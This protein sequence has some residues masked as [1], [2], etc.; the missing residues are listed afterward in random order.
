MRLG[1]GASAAGAGAG[2]G[3]AAAAAMELEE[4]GG[5][6]AGFSADWTRRQSLGRLIKAST[7]TSG[8]FSMANFVGLSQIFR[9]RQSNGVT[10]SF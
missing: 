10:L 9:A 2:S 5:G 8:K 4:A 1:L 7:G 3:L 6:R